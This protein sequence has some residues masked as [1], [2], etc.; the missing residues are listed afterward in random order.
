MVFCTGCRRKFKPSGY[1]I[2]I[3]RS[4]T[5]ACGVAYRENLQ[6]AELNNSCDDVEEETHFQGDFF[7]DYDESDLPWPV[8]AELDEDNEVLEDDDYMDLNADRHEGGPPN[9]AMMQEGAD[10]I[11]IERFPSSNAG[12]AISDDQGLVETDYD[13]YK[14]QCGNINDHAPFA[15]R[16]EWDIARWAKVHGITSTAVTELLGING[17]GF[18]VIH[19]N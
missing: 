1:T 11:F 7:G 14:K 6:A 4:Q 16:V 12:A 19:Y 15:S 18:D 13:S 9:H 2:H 8:E 10:S 5:S 3:R 17:V